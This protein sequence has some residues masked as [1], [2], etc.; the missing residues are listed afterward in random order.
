MVYGRAR[1]LGALI[2]GAIVPARP[3]AAQAPLPSALRGDQAS[4]PL[5]T[6]GL[7]IWPDGRPR[8]SVL[9]P[10]PAP[11][12]T[13]VASN[14]T[15]PVAPTA[16]LDL[17]R[18]FASISATVTSL[19]DSLVALARAQIGRRYKFGGTTPEH[20]FDCSGFVRYVMSALHVP[21]PRT[22]TEQAHTGAVI[23]L[24]TAQLR[25]GDLVTF[26]SARRISHIGIYVGG[27]RFVQASSRAGRVIETSLDRPLV[28]GA[29]PWRGARR[30]MIE[31]EAAN[32]DPQSVTRLEDAG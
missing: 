10:P 13:P 1:L 4:D 5:D 18:P 12:A 6:A 14:Q 26:G 32:D 31:D 16:P 2:V 25:P 19:R 23:A 15:E 28:H 22:A 21:L 3:V 29:K 11:L 7:M 24:D 8:G 27:G 20:G 9:V 17:A 30:V